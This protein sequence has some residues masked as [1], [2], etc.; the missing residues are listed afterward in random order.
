MKIL[1]SILTIFMLISGMTFAQDLSGLD[2]I[3][4]VYDRPTG[5]DMTGNLIMTIE[6]SRG[7]QRVREIKQF[8]KSVKNGE[9]KIMFF[10]SS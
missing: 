7:N 8:V 5:N 10:F 4:K 6:N 9:K 3:Q 1:K 2:V